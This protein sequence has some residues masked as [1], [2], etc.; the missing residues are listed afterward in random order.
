MELEKLEEIG[1]T[2]GEIKVYEALL[3]LGSS[4]KTPIAKNSGISPG[5]VYDVLERLIRKGLVSS[6]KE[7][8]VMHFKVAHPRQILNFLE[9]KKRKTQEEET[10]VKSMLPTLIEKYSSK[11]EKPE[12]EVYHGWK[13][14]ETVYNELVAYLKKGEIDYVFGASRGSEQEK[15]EEF[16]RKFN[17]KRSEKGIKIKMIYNLKDKEHILSYANNVEMLRFMELQTPAEVNLYNGVV[18][19]IILTLTPVA[20][21]IRSKE[22][23]ESFKQYFDAMWELAKD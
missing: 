8:K 6:I 15:T 23:F 3:Y 20:I 14:L 9:E 10:L 11:T 17:L 19:I 18:M 22:A 16:Y 2:K 5:K 21:V 13:G 1:L 7:G 12:V 4:T